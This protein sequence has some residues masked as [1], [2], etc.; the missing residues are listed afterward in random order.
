MSCARRGEM[1]R[2]LTNDRAAA[3]LLTSKR[4]EPETAAERPMSWRMVPTATTSRS[5]SMPFA[6]PIFAANYHERM[7]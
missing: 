1:P 3:A 7:A 5:Q 4:F 6:C 2:S